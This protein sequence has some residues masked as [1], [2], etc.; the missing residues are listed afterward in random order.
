MR[1]LLIDRI[2]QLEVNRQLLAI[3]NVTLSEDVYSE[4]F[5]GFPVM[6]GAL[7]VECLAQAGT[8][9]LEVSTDFKKKALLVLLERAKFR[10]MVHP[11]DQ[12][13]IAVKILSTDD[14][15]VQMDGTIHVSERLVVNARLVFTLRDA[16]EFYPPKT[17]HLMETIYDFWLKDAQI[18]GM[19]EKKEE[20]Q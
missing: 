12:L 17:K 10:A 8:A 6:P 16:N 7:L 18:V 3:K 14:R 15:F 5:F 19:H 11:G 13:A 9:L 4:H 1:Y 20:R 2:R